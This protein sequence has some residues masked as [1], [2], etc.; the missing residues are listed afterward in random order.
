[1]TGTNKYYITPVHYFWNLIVREKLPL[2]INVQLLKNKS[3]SNKI[4]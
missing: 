2:E 3:E 1:M 4:K